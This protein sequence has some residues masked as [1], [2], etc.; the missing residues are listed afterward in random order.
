MLD[1]F[2]PDHIYIAVEG[3][4]GLATRRYCLKRQLRFTTAYHSRFPEY[5]K[6]RVGIPLKWMYRFERWFHG[7]AASVMVSSKSLKDEL[8]KWDIKHLSLWSPGVDAELFYPDRTLV[9]EKTKPI[10]IYMGRLAAEKNIDAFLQLSLPGTM[11]VI[12]DGPDRKRLESTYKEVVFVGYKF[13]SELV[14]YLGMAD[15]FVFPS[16]TDTFGLVMLEAN[17]CGVPVAAL[18]SQASSTVIVPGVNG[19][20][21]QDLKTACLE[22]L[23]LSREQCRKYALRYGWE[24][25]TE[26]FLNNLVLVR[27]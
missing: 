21:N 13:G 22:A 7:P 6:V 19:V 5:V 12:G 16:L 11:Y 14:K 4:L 1:S 27:E 2:N 8:E 23:Q 17:A 15:V 10:F 26:L 20:I 9:T 24:H 25:S 18:P 3:P